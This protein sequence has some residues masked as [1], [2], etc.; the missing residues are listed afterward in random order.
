[1]AGVTHTRLDIPREGYARNP[2]RFAVV[3][4]DASSVATSDTSTLQ[5]DDVSRSAAAPHDTSLQDPD[6][7]RRE[8]QVDASFR[9]Y[10]TRRGAIGSRRV[11]AW[12]EDPIRPN[13]RRDSVY[14][15]KRCRQANHRFVS[16]RRDPSTTPEDATAPLRLAYADPPY[17]GLSARYYRDHPDFAGEVDL[18]SL[19]ASLTAEYDGWALSTSVPALR[20][21]LAL[22]PP[23]VRVASWHR[24]ERPTASWHPLNG[25]EPVIYHPARPLWA[26][27]TDRRVDTLQYVARARTTDPKR[28]VGAKPAAFLFWIFDLLAAAP[29]DTFVD[30][31]PG[32]GGAARAWETFRKEGEVAR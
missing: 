13:A 29:D 1:M 26:G 8:D 16:H 27:T 5:R 22:C 17:P 30:L 20:D 4:D 11:C 19:V 12:C 3:K 25:W 24:G 10:T 28:V 7:T 2:S 9:T 31:F 23:D 6:T 15:S 21:V 32:S 18:V 14:C